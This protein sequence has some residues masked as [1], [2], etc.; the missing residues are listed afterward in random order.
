VSDASRR[1]ARSRR[2][3]GR[4]GSSVPSWSCIAERPPSPAPAPVHHPSTAFASS[5]TGS[6][7]GSEL[8]RDPARPGEDHDRCT[9]AAGVRPEL[10]RPASALSALASMDRP[11][12]S[13]SRSR[14]PCS[15]T[16]SALSAPD[17]MAPDLP[18]PAACSGYAIR[19]IHIHGAW[20]RFSPRVGSAAAI[21]GTRAATTR[22][23]RPDR[24]RPRAGS[25]AAD[26]WSS[27]GYSWH[28]C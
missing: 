25:R 17:G 5:E 19:A 1:A 6:G 27:E 16:R 26:P 23:P 9:R 13:E 22:S 14:R 12:T 2:S 10:R 7:A 28:S 3:S 15:C 24:A 18:V 20:D 21:R 8:A 11:P 4:P